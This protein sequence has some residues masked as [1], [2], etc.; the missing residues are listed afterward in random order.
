MVDL[1]NFISLNIPSQAFEQYTVG[2]YNLENFFDFQNDKH[3]LDDDFTTLGRNE[4]NEARYRKKLIKISDAIS[5]IGT[6]YTGNLPAVLGVAEV[7]NKK[8]LN[9][10]IDQ[11]KLKNY[12]YD[13]IHFNSPDER[14]IDCAL[15]YRK[16][17]FTIIDAQPIPILLNDDEGR[18]DTTRD[19]LYVKGVMAGVTL[20]IYVNHWPSRRDG[21]SSTTHKRE[22]TAR[23]LMEHIN[24]ID[25][26]AN[27]SIEKESNNMFVMILGDFN[28]DPENDSIKKGILPYGFQNITAP[29]K[30]FHRGSL[31]YKKK[32]NLFDQI[33]VSDNFFNDIPKSLYVHKADI[34][35][36]IMLRQWKGK[37]RGHPARTF[38]RGRY[39][40][41]YSD[42]FP[43]YAVLRRN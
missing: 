20:H 41:G 8:V 19:I 11:P 26:Q 37:Y 1:T 3:I 31:N 33:M 7:E 29:L 5:Q 22:A 15:L 38:I 9:D 21:A 36:D 30:N 2:F 25:P 17:V 4:W 12:P 10:L 35:D 28:D 40:G 42:H 14:G 18:R 34:F 6:Q 32:W 24:K 23:Q 16:D 13:Y 43:V 39:A 27:R